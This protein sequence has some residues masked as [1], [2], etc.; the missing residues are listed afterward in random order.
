MESL[1]LACSSF[2]HHLVSHEEIKVWMLLPFVLLSLAKLG[3]IFWLII[4]VM[5][6]QE[7]I[8]RL[9]ENRRKFAEEA[10]DKLLGKLEKS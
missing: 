4:R 6:F 3:I 1:A 2:W 8:D 7:R 5:K 10:L 9:E